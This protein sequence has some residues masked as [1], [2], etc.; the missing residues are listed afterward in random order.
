MTNNQTHREI[1]MNTFK[2]EM[3]ALLEKHNVNAFAISV[4]TDKGAKQGVQT[5]LGGDSKAKTLFLAL[6]MAKDAVDTLIEIEDGEEG[7]EQCDCPRCSPQQAEEESIEDA[8]DALL[9]KLLDK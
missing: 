2:K 4:M 5:M 8:I 1:L 9:K 6:E 3:I 7:E